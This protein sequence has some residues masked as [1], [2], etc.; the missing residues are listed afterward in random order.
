MNREKTPRVVAVPIIAVVSII[1]I[2][3]AQISIGM[4]FNGF[5][6]AHLSPSG[7]SPNTHNMKTQRL[8][9]AA[10]LEVL[11]KGGVMS[12][13]EHQ[14]SPVTGNRLSMWKGVSLD[15]IKNAKKC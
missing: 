10:F 7:S 14:S 9:V 2:C 15:L 8:S 3:I 11:L 4:L 1:P 5:R 13:Y 12:L 6:S